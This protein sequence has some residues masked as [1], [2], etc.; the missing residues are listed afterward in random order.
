MGKVEREVN[1]RTPRQNTGRATE[2][3]FIPKPKRAEQNLSLP[4]QGTVEQTLSLQTRKSENRQVSSTPKGARPFQERRTLTQ[5]SW[6]PGYNLWVCSK[7]RRSLTQQDCAAFQRD[8]PCGMTTSTDVKIQP[9]YKS[10][11]ITA[12]DNQRSQGEKHPLPLA[13]HPFRRG[14]HH[15]SLSVRHESHA[16]V[17]TETPRPAVPVHLQNPRSLSRACSHL[18]VES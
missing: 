7:R 14:T 12:L 1:T 18:A 11:Q 17:V 3:H 5:G 10:H 15:P 9:S 4:A 16:P 13:G 8:S 2:T 6:R